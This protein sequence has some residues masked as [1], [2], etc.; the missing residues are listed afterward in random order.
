MVLNPISVM[1]PSLALLI[2]V[3]GLFSCS[4]DEGLPLTPDLVSEINVYDLGNN[5]NSSDIRLKFEVKNNL[6]VI[7]YRIVI[8]PSSFSDSFDENDAAS[9][10]EASY[11]RVVPESFIVEYSFHRLQSGLLDVSGAQIQD[12]IEYVTA[13]FV[14]GDGNRQLSEFS[15][16]FTLNDQGIYSGRYIVLEQGTCVDI[17]GAYGVELLDDGRTFIDLSGMENDYS[18]IIKFV[19]S[20]GLLSNYDRIEFSVDGT[21]ITNYTQSWPDL[22]CWSTSTTV[23]NVGVDPCPL[24]GQGNEG[25]II[26]ELR[27]EINRKT[28]DC[29]RTCEGTIIFVR[30]Y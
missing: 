30:Q 4:D 19:E 10:P 18:G 5:G 22:L 1:K 14:Q 20:S 24:F 26:D 23:C 9:I 3:V 21:T 7:E 11:L 17:N 16:P 27:I 2:L 13:V 8:V 28:E 6:N 15:I 25:I 29:I 12:D